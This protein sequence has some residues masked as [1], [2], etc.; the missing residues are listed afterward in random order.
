MARKDAATKGSKAAAK[1]NEKGHDGVLDVTIVLLEGGYASTAIAPVE[2]FQSAGLLW[3]S[4]RGNPPQPRFRVRT[5]SLDGAPVRSACSIGLMPDCSIRDIERTDIVVI[6]ASGQDVAVR[7]ARESALLPWVKKMY[8]DGAYLASVCT[9]VV[10]LS[11][12]GLL[13]GRQAITHWAVADLLRERYPK[14][15]WRPEQFVTEDGGVFCSG[16]VYA[17]IDLSL[18]LVEK[19]CG[20]E[21]A[22]QCAKSLLV[23]MPRSRQSG[24]AVALLAR[25]H[26]DDRVKKAEEYMQRHFEGDVTIETLADQ[27]G[28][29]PRNFV[30]RFKAATGRLPNTYVQM[31]RIAAAKEMLEEGRLPVQNICETIGYENVAFFR[32][33]FKRHTGMTPAEYRSSFAP[34]RVGRGELK[35]GM[36]SND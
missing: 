15:R 34:L 3:N 21:L 22:L 7:I 23:S 4:L 33:V 8:D 29:S 11:G 26:G 16:G 13:D 18:Y 32:D 12:C 5:A 2:V 27:L 19:F 28:M 31:L 10:F 9:G 20:H 14:V 17:A 36:H 35:A 30:R 24:Y 1:R 6:A 25:P